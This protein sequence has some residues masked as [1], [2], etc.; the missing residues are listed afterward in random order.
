MRGN[1]RYAGCGKFVFQAE[2]GGRE[3]RNEAA[4]NQRSA[5]RHAAS[6]KIE[7]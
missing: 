3:K 6:L 7:M 4:A 2:L 1:R 5:V